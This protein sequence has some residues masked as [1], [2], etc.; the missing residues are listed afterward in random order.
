MGRYDPQ[1]RWKVKNPDKDR[2]YCRKAQV[3]VRLKVLVQYDNQCA[4]CGFND[5]R[6]LELDHPNGGGHAERKKL[7]NVGVYRRAL[8]HPNEYQLL[9]ANCNRIKKV[10][11]HEH[12][13]RINGPRQ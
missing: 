13:K 8:K 12:R 2:G 10:E 4:F 6:A 9:C 1:E 7:G 3:N 5:P 11:R